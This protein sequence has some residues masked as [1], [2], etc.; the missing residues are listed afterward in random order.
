MQR[1][2]FDDL[3]YLEY[4]YYT[5]RS[6]GEP[7]FSQCQQLHGKARD[8]RTAVYAINWGI[9]W[10]TSQRVT[11]S[12]YAPFMLHQIL[13]YQTWTLRQGW[14]LDRH[15]P[16]STWRKVKWTLL[17]STMGSQRWFRPLPIDGPTIVAWLFGIFLV[18]SHSSWRNFLQ[19]TY[20]RLHLPIYSTS[21]WWNK[22]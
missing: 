19:H 22:K 6:D 14:Y 2:S 3:R 17:V 21:A 7:G 8:L 5:S 16:S 1:N 13:S 4:I 15:F 10:L 11:P 12:N 9:L 18:A 20:P